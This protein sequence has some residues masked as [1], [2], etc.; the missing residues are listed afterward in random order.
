MKIC[1]PAAGRAGTCELSVQTAQVCLSE[2]DAP[3]EAVLDLAG[4]WPSDISW[5]LCGAISATYTTT[6]LQFE[7][8]DVTSA[9][10]TDLLNADGMVH[11]EAPSPAPS[12]SLVPT[13]SAMPTPAPSATA[14]LRVLNVRTF[15]ELKSAVESAPACGAGRVRIQLLNHVRM[16]PGNESVQVPQGSCV[17]VVGVVEPSDAWNETTLLRKWIT[18][19]P[20]A[21]TVSTNP[22]SW[23][24]TTDAGCTN[25]APVALRLSMRDAYGDGWQGAR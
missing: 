15:G 21:P 20:S 3:F 7:W 12:L 11:T 5:V 8:A 1:L 18:P 23:A 22:P 10:R 19:A 13:V 9:Y 24:P 14:A 2:D 17:D 16:G 4:S 6:Y 25:T